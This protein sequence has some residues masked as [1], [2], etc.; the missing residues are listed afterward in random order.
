M[1]NAGNN[2]PFGGGG[3][4]RG[5]FGG[6]RGAFSSRYQYEPVAPEYTNTETAS[7]LITKVMGLLAF[8]FLFAFIGTFVGIAI[9]LT[10]STYWI[11][12]I[13]G[14][15]VLIALNFAI[16]KPGLNIFLLYLFTFLEGLALAPIVSLYLAANMG[17]IV[18][19][20]FLITAVTSFGLAAYAW[21]TK[22]DFSGLGGKLFLGLILLLVASLVSIF[23]HST[24]FVFLIC[25]AGVGL[26]S[27]YLLYYVQRAKYMADTLPNAIGLTVSIFITVLNLFLYILEILTIL[28]GGR[29]NS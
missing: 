3:Y 23:F 6:R 22:R 24:F 20:A 26:F 16:N 17:N 8:S 14:L 18:G 25:V 15:V 5:G 19:E 10:Y 1:F 11:V 2:S 29:R 9:H 4:N 21:T 28:Q 13:G 12:A 27:A 7:S